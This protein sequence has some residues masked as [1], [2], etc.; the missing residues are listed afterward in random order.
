MQQ[1]ISRFMPD[2]ELKISLLNQKA[3]IMKRLL[4]F[5][6]LGFIACSVFAQQDLFN[7]NPIISPE[8]N[9]NHSVTFR[10]KALEAEMV[11]VSGSLDGAHAFAPITYDME[12][13]EWCLDLYDFSV[14]FRILPV[15]F[16]H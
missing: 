2:E 1:A 4:F 7:E 15:L 16:C 3:L 5:F 8:I 12:K 10:V 14:A 6:S 11:Q 9:V 13:G